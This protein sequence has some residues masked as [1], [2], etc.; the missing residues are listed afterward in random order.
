MLMTAFQSEVMQMLGISEKEISSIPVEQESAFYASAY[1]LY[2]QGDYRRSAKLF[3][4]LVLSDPFSEDY[5][6]GLASAKQMA[7]EYLAAVHAWGLLALLK[8]ADPIPHFHAAECLLS[9]GEKEE[10]LKALDAALELCREEPLRE[11]IYL[12]KAIHYVPH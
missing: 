3:T 2:E 1:G 5:W 6:Q 4:Q 9:L 12:L 8:E 10:A 7:R 11:K